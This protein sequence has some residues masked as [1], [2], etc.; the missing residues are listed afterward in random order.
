MS[1]KVKMVLLVTPV[2]NLGFDRCPST[3]SAENG[4]SF[5]AGLDFIKKCLEV[6]NGMWTSS[7]VAF[8]NQ[9]SV[10]S[11]ICL[12]NSSLLPLPAFQSTIFSE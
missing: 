10:I 4:C 1:W 9:V 11:V 8:P 7:H 2:V 6:D 12:N 5:S 3:S